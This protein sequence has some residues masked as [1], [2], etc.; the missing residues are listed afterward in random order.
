M[1]QKH[2]A[3][4]WNAAIRQQQIMS[5]ATLLHPQDDAL[6]LTEGI[7]AIL[8]AQPVIKTLNGKAQRMHSKP[9]RQRLA[10]NEPE[11]GNDKENAQPLR[12]GN[13]FVKNTPRCH[14]LHAKDRQPHGQR[15]RQAQR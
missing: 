9:G 12:R 5:R 1:E 8:A 2:Q 7:D 4:A 10:L 15:I 13:A 14:Q 6:R 11:A 3:A